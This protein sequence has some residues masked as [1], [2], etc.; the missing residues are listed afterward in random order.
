LK[1]GLQV[2]QTDASHNRYSPLQ[3]T[4]SEMPGR[5]PADE[6]LPKSR[7]LLGRLPVAWSLSLKSFWRFF[8]Q[9]E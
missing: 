5:W 8:D 4:A 9:S 6:Y 1:A 2:N 3:P 7:T